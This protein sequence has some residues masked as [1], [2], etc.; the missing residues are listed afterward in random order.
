[1]GREVRSRGSTQF[2]RATEA[3]SSWWPITEPPERYTE[4]RGLFQRSTRRW[5]SPYSRSRGSQSRP[6][7]LL[8]FLWLLVLF[9]IFDY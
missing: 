1:M 8:A 2:S 4:A 6:L 7:S 3:L 9:I 5:F